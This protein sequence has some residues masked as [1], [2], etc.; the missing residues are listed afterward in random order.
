MFQSP[1]HNNTLSLKLSEVMEDIGVNEEMVMKRRKVFMLMESIH[2]VSHRSAGNNTT[3]YYLGSQS[4]GTTT[5]GLHSDVD[6]MYVDYYYVIQNWS[7]WKQNKRNY[8]MIQDENVSPGYCFL[9]LL[10]SDEPV[11]ATHIPNEHYIRD[12]YYIR[13][14]LLIISVKMLRDK[15]HQIVYRDMKDTVTGI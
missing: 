9:Q 2:T 6:I 15:G 5:Q 13:I 1:D 11:P 4:E 8:L 7:E 10:R 3:A 14:L 12:R